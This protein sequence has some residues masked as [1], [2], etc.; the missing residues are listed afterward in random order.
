MAATQY[1]TTCTGIPSIDRRVMSEPLDVDTVDLVVRARTGEPEAVNALM[2]RALP[3]MR[4]WARGRLPSHARQD[5]DTE[6]LVQD[7]MAAA[8][9]RLDQ[10]P[11]GHTGALQAYLR[12]ALANH[13][14]TRIRHSLQH[15]HEPIPP[16]ILE[17]GL[18]SPLEAA[19]GRDRLEQY[20]RAL[21]SLRASDR[22]LVVMRL[23]L[24]YDY[25]T[26]ARVI[27]KPSPS[28][29]RVAVQRAVF[30]LASQLSTK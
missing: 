17:S 25:E 1:Y 3:A 2:E 7:V 16:E 27:G 15:A 18:P 21:A 22:D 11:T 26:I 23:E 24:Q 5:G 13:V 9:K 8:L 29:A 6:D 19:I 20:E 14:R 4:R 30:R 28:A 10:L 12:Q